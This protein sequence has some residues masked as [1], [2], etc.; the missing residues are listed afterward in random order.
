[1]NLRDL[2][3]IIA[4]S[5]HGHFGKAA[6]ACNVSQP[7]LSGQIAK[8]E[9][10]LGITVFHRVGRSV[11]PT[12][13]GEEIIEH[14]RRAVS[15]SQDI[16]DIARANRDPLSGRLRLGVIPTLGPYLMPY[17]L[18]A[19]AEKL[20][21]AP[22]VI[23]ED[24]TGNLVPLVAQGKLDAAIIATPPEPP[25][26]TSMDLFEEPFSVATPANHPLLALKVVKPSDIDPKSLLL[27]S[28]GHC[29]RD[30]VVDLC[31]QQEAN[32]AGHAD[33]RATSLETL[34]H[35]VGAGFG[36]TLVPQMAIESG[37]AAGVQIA[38]RPL[39][40]DANRH[41]RLIYRRNSPRLKALVELA[42]LIR[43][44]LPEPLR[45]LQK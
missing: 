9:E 13:A 36:V 32:I 38:I 44:S 2:Q 31:R 15:A 20:P 26:I 1:M 24:L 25:E 11:R 40:G 28:D 22:L 7:T 33:I 34:L 41:I 23:V 14:A 30:Q 21:N 39:A 27:L 12:E 5:E 10:E 43:A 35:L 4:L 42:R 8:L 18:P 16:V 29:L 45:K 6:A 17:V 37:R 19:A 3:Y